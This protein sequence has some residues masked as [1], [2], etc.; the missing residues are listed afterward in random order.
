MSQ[1]PSLSLYPLPL[2]PELMLYLFDTYTAITLPG[3]P[4][5]LTLL[6]LSRYHYTRNISRLYQDLKLRQATVGKFAEVWNRWVGYVTPLLKEWPDVPIEILLNHLDC[7]IRAPSR[8]VE[9]STLTFQNTLSFVNIA[10]M[11]VIPEW[12][13]GVWERHPAILHPARLMQEARTIIF[14]EQMLGGGDVRVGAYPFGENPFNYGAE[15][16]V[17]VMPS[18]PFHCISPLALMWLACLGK[19]T[20]SVVR[21]KLVYKMEQID[22]VEAKIKSWDHLSLHI[23]VSEPSDSG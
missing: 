17:I 3:Q 6:T 8:T 11:L 13:E 15:N 18:R 1:L 22:Q 5:F 14:E 19:F 2:P 7:P 9:I 10:E 21:V 12:D 16:L 4:E 23:F 20:P